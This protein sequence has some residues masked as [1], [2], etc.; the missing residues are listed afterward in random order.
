[1]ARQLESPSHS[2]HVCVDHYPRLSECVPQHDIRG[3]SPHPRQGRERCH[4]V[5]NLFMKL[6][7]HDLGALYKIVGLGFEEPGGTNECLHLGGTGFRI[8][9]WPTIS[10]KE[11]RSH[12]ID[13]LVGA[14]RRQNGGHE[15]F[16]GIG[17]VEF[18]LHVGR[19]GAQYSQ[20]ATHA[21]LE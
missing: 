10:T 7:R 12:L 17:V 9:T 21:D 6:V 11:N 18:Y 4:R 2:F 5:R 8:V 3:F 16:P 13:T 15:K 1:M 14:L 19:R 20:Y